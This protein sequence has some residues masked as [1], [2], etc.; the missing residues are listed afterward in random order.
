MLLWRAVRLETHGE[1]D[2]RFQGEERMGANGS[3]GN[4]TTEGKS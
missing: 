2:L 3:P 1:E 4:A